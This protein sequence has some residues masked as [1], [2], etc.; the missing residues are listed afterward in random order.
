MAKTSNR[1]NPAEF[2]KATR[3]A[4]KYLEKNPTE[5]TEPSTH[6]LYASSNTH[7]LVKGLAVAGG[8]AVAGLA[9]FGGISFMKTEAAES[10]SRS[11]CELNSGD[12]S[13]SIEV[14]SAIR[15]SS[16]LNAATLVDDVIVHELINTGEVRRGVGANSGLIA[17][18]VEVETQPGQDYSS[19]ELSNLLGDELDATTFFG[20]FYRYA[21]EYEVPLTGVAQGCAKEFDGLMD[22]IRSDP[23][24]FET[25]AIPAKELIDQ[26]VVFHR[27]DFAPF[28]SVPIPSERQEIVFVHNDN[29]LGCPEP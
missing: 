22:A 20:S 27:T 6:R 8:F 15:V 25:D 4:R 14:E 19:T 9:V 29:I 24:S 3:A 11:L 12:K 2:D 21:Q 5:T 13:C 23:K 1:F 18:V 16:R 10:V 26:S 28:T 7:P 17:L